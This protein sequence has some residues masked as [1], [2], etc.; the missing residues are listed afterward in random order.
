LTF[1]SSFTISSVTPPETMSS[2]AI[3]PVMNC[4]AGILP[5]CTSSMTWAC[6]PQ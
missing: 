5:Y 1:S 2:T 3:R 4:S 6:S